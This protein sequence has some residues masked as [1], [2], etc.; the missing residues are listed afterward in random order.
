MIILF[1]C[2]TYVNTDMCKDSEARGPIVHY[3]CHSDSECQI[4]VGPGF[5]CVDTNCVPPA[6]FEKIHIQASKG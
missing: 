5:T 4:A 1:T 6:Q 3:P 2:I